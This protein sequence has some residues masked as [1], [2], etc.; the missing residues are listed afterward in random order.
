MKG[1]DRFRQELSQSSQQRSYHRFVVKAFHRNTISFLNRRGDL[2]FVN[3]GEKEREIRMFDEE[4]LY[5]KSRCYLVRFSYRIILE[6]LFHF[7]NFQFTSSMRTNEK[8]KT[9]FEAKLIH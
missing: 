3:W 8:M 7:T 9:D 2:F 4:Y 1:G 6:F 5:F